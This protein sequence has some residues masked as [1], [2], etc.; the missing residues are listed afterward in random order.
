MHM[1]GIFLPFCGVPVSWLCH[2]LLN[3]VFSV[4]LPDRCTAAC[5]VP[6]LAV[7][8]H[9]TAQ[10]ACPGL[11]TLTVLTLHDLRDPLP[12]H[13]A[14][15]VIAGAPPW[16]PAAVD[17]AAAAAAAAAV[18]CVIVSVFCCHFSN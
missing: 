15:L 9:A 18:C 14:L 12:V 17:A 7:P 4:G 3:L 6:A 10:V 13:Q 2:S 8:A 16:E 1:H 5:I 11:G